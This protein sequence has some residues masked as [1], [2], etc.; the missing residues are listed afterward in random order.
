MNFEMAKG[1]SPEDIA[2]ATQRALI[3]SMRD[4]FKLMKAE[5]MQPG[6][7]WEQIEY[8]LVQ[9]E[10]KKPAIFEQEEEM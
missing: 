5:I 7:T 2:K 10:K 6:L 4:I 1:N 8:I 3:S 9:F